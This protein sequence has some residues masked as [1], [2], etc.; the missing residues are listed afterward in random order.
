MRVRLTKKLA[1]KIDGIDLRGRA[2]GDTLDLNP[3]DAA[4]LVAEGWAHADRRK[5][6]RHY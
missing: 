4:V 1:E 6:T 3:R 2:I 5:A